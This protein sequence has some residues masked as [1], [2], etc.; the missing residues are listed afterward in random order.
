MSVQKVKIPYNAELSVKTLSVAEEFGVNGS[1]TL[2]G[3]VNLTGTMNTGS[4][5]LNFSDGPQSKQGVPSITK[6]NKIFSSYTL[7]S[8]D[9]RDSIIEMNLKTAGTLTIPVDTPA[10]TFPIGTTID[11]IQTNSGQITIGSA[12]GVNLNATPGLKIRS[13]WSIATLLKRDANT[14]LVFGD[15]TA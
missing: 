4:G 8:L 11:V 15:L 2:G 5:T 12:F 1:A 14:W 7:S 3:T 13:Q 10:L 6:I 9:E